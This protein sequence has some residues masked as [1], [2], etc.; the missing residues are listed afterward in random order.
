MIYT[1]IVT[2]LGTL[3]ITYLWIKVTKHLKQ[4]TEDVSCGQK[5]AIILLVLSSISHLF[6]SYVVYVKHFN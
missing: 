4:Q 6:C 1:I 2:I 5:L 3:G